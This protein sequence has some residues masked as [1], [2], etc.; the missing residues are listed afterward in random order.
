MSRHHHHPKRHHHC[1]W[2][3]CLISVLHHHHHHHPPL[4][5]LGLN[6]ARQNEGKGLDGGIFRAT[7]FTVIGVFKKLK[8]SCHRP[9]ISVRSADSPACNRLGKLQY[10]LA[11]QSGAC[12]QGLGCM[13]V[14]D[15]FADVSGGEVIHC[16]TLVYFGS[17]LCLPKA[18]LCLHHN[19]YSA[20]LEHVSEP[21]LSVTA[22][23]I[24]LLCWLSTS[25]AAQQ[26]PPCPML[27]LFNDRWQA[28]IPLH[29][30]PM[31]GF[32]WQD[33]TEPFWLGCHRTWRKCLIT[34]HL[35]GYRSV[36]QT[37]P[38]PPSP[39]RN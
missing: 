27:V 17:F 11:E 14:M 9:T 20:P 13:I 1:W 31:Q 16:T 8:V 12:Q 19:F 5:G 29:Y 2:L 15:T 37:R 32:D 21:L 34:P 10:A 18:L 7:W 36:C 33:H 28:F 38:H 24:S 22:E 39:K 25:M 4:L 6:L 3:T 23:H 30:Q 35:L 26:W